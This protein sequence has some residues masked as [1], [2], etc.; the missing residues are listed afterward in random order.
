M[1]SKITLHT[2]RKVD[3][4]H[5]RKVEAIGIGSKDGELAIGLSAGANDGVTV[6]TQYW[7]ATVTGDALGILE[8]FEVSETTCLCGVFDMI[9][10]DFWEGLEARMI[11]DPSPPSGVTVTGYVPE[12]SIRTVRQLLKNW[13]ESK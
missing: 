13:E 11:R 6:G 9:N 5:S 2:L 1:L 8:V 4:F 3:E 10:V 7:L 12:E